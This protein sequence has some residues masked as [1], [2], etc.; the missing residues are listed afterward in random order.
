MLLDAFSYTLWQQIHDDIVQTPSMDNAEH[1]TRRDNFHDK[2]DPVALGSI[3]ET[4]ERLAEAKIPSHVEGEPMQPRQH[5]DEI[6]V[7]PPL[8]THH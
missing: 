8:Q 5:V 6:I 7:R 4:A 1:G 3:A 2:G